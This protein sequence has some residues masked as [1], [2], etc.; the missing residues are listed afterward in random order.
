MAS[1]STIIERRMQGHAGYA[2]IEG[3]AELVA[4]GWRAASGRIAAFAESRRQAQ[5]RRE[6]H[7]LSDRQL[8]DIGLERQQ[9]GRLFR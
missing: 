4:A 9:I 8:R 1:S 2:F 5:A 6:L 7:D 3:I